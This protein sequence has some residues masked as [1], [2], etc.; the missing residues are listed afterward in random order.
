MKVLIFG[1]NGGIGHAI[2]QHLAQTIPS[3]EVHATY[4]NTRPPSS[5]EAIIWHQLDVTNEAKV[6]LLANEIK[7]LD[8]IIN[9]VGLLHDKHHG[10][11]KNLKSF[12][13]DFYLKNIMNNA[14]PT[15]LIAKHFQ[16][17][18]KHSSQP[19][20]ATIS[21]KVGSIKDNQLGG[22]YSYRSSKAALNMLLKTLSIEWGRTMPKACVLSLHPG[23]TD[24]ELS[25]PFQ[26]NVPE[27]K[28]FEPDRVAAVLVKIISE[29]TSDISG[30]FLSYSGEELPW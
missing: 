11:E 26:A 9:A 3:T 30:S 8:W 29:A 5:H 6:Q 1:G 23:T 15:M 22:W 13:P 21:A 28:L 12:D 14:M 16:S 18:F 19:K 10:P 20:L 24:T 4:R 2:C 27:G 17:A 25:K 7:S